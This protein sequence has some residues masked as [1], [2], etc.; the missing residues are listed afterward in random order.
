[1]T[2]PHSLA[3]GDLNA[4]IPLKVRSDWAAAISVASFEVIYSSGPLKSI[5]VQQN[6]REPDQQQPSCLSKTETGAESDSV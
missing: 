5:V 2:H 4:I 3:P 6:R 1:M